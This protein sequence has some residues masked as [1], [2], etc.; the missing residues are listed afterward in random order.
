VSFF[1]LMKAIVWANQRAFHI[2]FQVFP[3][4][5]VHSEQPAVPIGMEFE[6]PVASHIAGI[7][8]VLDEVHPEHAIFAIALA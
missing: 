4:A 3:Q 2:K 7:P 5:I 6:V 8:A 1:L